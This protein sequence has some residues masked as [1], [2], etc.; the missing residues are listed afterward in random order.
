MFAV[1]DLETTGG[2][3]RYERIIEVA[4]VVYDGEKI[5]EEYQSLVNPERLI[6]PNITRLTGIS[7]DMVADA[8]KFYEI[9]KKVVELTEDK[10]FV[11]HN[12]N[13]DYNFLRN[14]YQ[15]L[16]F[17]YSRKKV[18][19]V[20]L[21]RKLLPGRPSYG[22]GVLT[23][24]L[25][26]KNEARHRAMG[27]ARATTELLSILIKND[28]M[29]VIH[30]AIMRNPVLSGLHDHLKE[31]DLKALPQK[32][33]IYFFYNKDD[34]LIYVGKSNNI[35]DRV[36]A[37]LNNQSPGKY[38][39]LKASIARIDYQLVAGEVAT[40]LLEAE[41]IIKHKP[42]F[43][44]ALKP[45]DVRYHIR[46]FLA[47]NGLK[48]LEIYSGK[49]QGDSLFSYRSSWSARN[50]LDQL[51]ED[52]GFCSEFV[53]ARAG[54]YSECQKSQFGS[55]PGACEGK[56]IAGEYNK[57]IERLLQDFEVPKGHWALLEED[58]FGKYSA[59]L[60]ENGNV[61]GL[62]ADFEADEEHEVLEIPEE[63]VI[64]T[65]NHRN[66]RKILVQNIRGE[67]VDKKDWKL[68]A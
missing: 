33:G 1:V 32:R 15:S 21:S 59:V 2:S 29:N 39:E 26:I 40:L 66:L 63:I 54:V 4:I 8:P 43:N 65:S 13:F 14:E 31:K 61:A 44:R 42:F 30:K 57:G 19:T 5:V 25:G 10:V 55:C 27:D 41:K 22:L 34:F 24:D 49:D 47:F 9:A 51:A 64:K 58:N 68:T 12:V 17:N 18:C 35:K 60:I 50:A 45:R 56:A 52:Y 6:P 23:R 3:Y 7:N 37:H 11:A 62:V 38:Q 28:Q 46:P 53:P 16:G 48:G 36:M 67:E 20:Q